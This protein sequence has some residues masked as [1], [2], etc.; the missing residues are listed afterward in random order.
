VKRTQ[1]W[2]IAVAA[3]A[4]RVVV[5]VHERKD[6]LT[7]FTD[8]SDDFAQTFVHHGTFGFVPGEPSA[9]TQPLYGFF[10]VPIYWIFGRHW[11][12]VGGAQIL[13]ATATAF[14]VY[15]IGARALSRRAG[16]V[17]AIVSALNPY[18][19]WHD[20]HLNREIL[21][22]LVGAAF[23]LCA[24]IAA[25]RRSLPWA[26]A[27]GVCG[28]LAI[29]GNVRLILLPVVVAV[30]LLFRAGWGWAPLALVAAATLTVAPWVVR[31]RVQVGCFALTT[32]ARALWKANNLQTYDLLASGKWIDDVHDPPGHPFPNP[33]EARDLYRQTG[34]KVH[35][36]ECANQRYYQ[37]RVRRFWR[38]HPGEKA[39]LAA[40]AVRMEWDPRTTASATESGQGAIRDWAQPLY[41]SVLFALGLAGAALAPRRFAA[42]A[43]GLLVYQTLA[44]MVFVGATRYRV[45]YDFLIA[46]LAAAALDWAYLRRRRTR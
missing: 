15:A 38:D 13:V 2:L 45:P 46:L 14:L 8:K 32:D 40:Q 23:V 17:A 1:L 42:L 39:K 41:T 33:E 36:N 10:L 37:R 19:V 30:Y 26:T 6:I 20:V 43:L 34:N 5:L 18:L 11:W 7:A 12:A 25:D 31:N 28:G 29:L 35:V 44:A 9:Y 22:Q 3:I 24:L 4:P 21:D 16:T 27:A